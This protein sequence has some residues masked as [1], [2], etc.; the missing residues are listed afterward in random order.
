MANIRTKAKV[1]PLSITKFLGLNLDETGDTQLQI[2]ESGNM[3]NW[4]ITKDMKLSKIEGYKSLMPGNIGEAIQGQWHGRVAGD[5]HYVFSYDGHIYRF[6]DDYWTD[7]TQWSEDWLT[8]TTDLGTIT[9]A[10]TYFFAFDDKLYMQN[11]NEYKSWDGNLANDFIDVVGYIPLIAIGTSPDGA[12]F[13]DFENTNLLTGKKRQQFNGDG[14]ATF[15]QLYETNVTSIDKVYVNGVLKTLTTDYTVN[16]SLGRIIPVNPATFSSGEDNIEGQWT[17]G[18]GFRSEV[19][20]NRRSILFGLSNNTRAFFYGNEDRQNRIVFSALAD[21]LPSVEYFP[22]TYDNV[23]GSSNTAITDIQKQY[24]RM[25]VTKEDGSAYTLKYDLYEDDGI[26]IVNFET[27]DLNDAYGNVAF[28][29]GQL[30][31][32]FPMTIDKGLTFWEATDIKSENNAVEIS[33]KIRP[34]LEKFDLSI[35]KTVDWQERFEHWTALDEYVY[36]YNYMLSSSEFR[37]FSKLKLNDKPNNFL[38][39]KGELY[40]GTKTGEIMKFSKNY[41][42]FN[43]HSINSHWEMNFYDFG[44]EYLRKNMQK[45]WV[46]LLPQ[47]KASAVINYISDADGV[48]EVPETIEYNLLSFEEIDFSDFSFLTNYNPQAFRIKMTAKKFT[49]LKITIDNDSVTDDAVILSLSTQVEFGGES[50]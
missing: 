9:D 26:A 27:F 35:A 44:A 10:E 25:I 21:G 47:A 16:L 36:I 8:H 17:K 20:N 29:Q 14:V 15:Y 33:G 19:L 42:S 3:V 49:H 6:D 41:K 7:D 31:K 13:T 2:G 11:G 23:V 12:T 18:S 24:D 48:G 22:S 32:N 43:G 30:I 4:Y 38:I 39:I 45:I 37:V 1:P 40:F 50:K 28:G 46:S 5:Y 34:D